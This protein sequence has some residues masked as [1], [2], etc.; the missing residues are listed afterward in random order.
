MSLSLFLLRWR[1]APPLKRRSRPIGEHQ[2]SLGRFLR[3]RQPFGLPRR[4]RRVRDSLVRPWADWFCRLDYQRR[5][6]A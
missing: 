2:T 3:L 1:C 6:H 5:R 4:A